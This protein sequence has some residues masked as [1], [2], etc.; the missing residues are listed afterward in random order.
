MTINQAL[1]EIL[2]ETVKALRDLDSDALQALEQRIVSLAKS[3]ESYE[4][5]NVGLILAKKQLLE[6]V[7]QNCQVNLDALTRLHARNMRKQW[8]Q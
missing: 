4:R 3:S 8:A 7:L 6:I 5:D 2:D 1:T